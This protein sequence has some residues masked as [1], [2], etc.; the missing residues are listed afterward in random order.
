MGENLCKWINWQG[1]NLPKFINT[2]CSSIPKKQAYQKMWRRSKQT[3]L[4]RR[5]T[6][7]QKYMK[8]CSVSLIIREMQIK[9]TMRYHLTPARMAIIKKSTNN[10]CWRGYGEKGTLV[11][12]WWGYKL[13]QP[14]WKAVR[15]FLT[16]QNSHLIQQSHSWASIQRKPWLTQTYVL[17]WSLQHYL[18]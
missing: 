13:V 3:V 10:K 7:G 9:T 11:H 8:R 14:L 1:I 6:D 12:C 2:F 4:Q 5:H 17:Q 16:A 15:R 18:Q